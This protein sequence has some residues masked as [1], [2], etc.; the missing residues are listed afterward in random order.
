MNS[1]LQLVSLCFS[2][3]YGVFFYLMAR[4]NFWVIKDMKIIKKY[5]LTV[6]LVVDVVLLY[7]FFMFKINNGSFHI[8]FILS[9]GLGFWL[10][11]KIYDLLKK[12]ISKMRQIVVKLAFFKQK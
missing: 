5:L 6:I 11:S 7:I 3:G 12:K 9:I 1:Y 8:Y 4:Y 2:F 10:M